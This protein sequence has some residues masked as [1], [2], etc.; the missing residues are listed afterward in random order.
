MISENKLVADHFN[1]SGQNVSSFRTGE[2]HM[3]DEQRK[4]KTEEEILTY[5]I[6]NKE[7]CELCL[8]KDKRIRELER[9]IEAKEEV[10]EVLR[11]NQ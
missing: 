4:T 5:L 10:I 8:E 11:K 9:L 2:G 6:S 3:P 1:R 7:E